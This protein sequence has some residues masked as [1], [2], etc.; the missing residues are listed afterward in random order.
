M[1]LDVRPRIPRGV[2]L[3]EDKV[4]HRWVLLAPERIFEVDGIGVEIL[5]RCDGS[6]TLGEII[7]GLAAA[8]EATPEQVT[9]DVTDFLQ[10]LATKRIIDL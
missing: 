1:E 2:R 3:R 6:T 4:R 7:A 9:P 8:Y 10:G 5:K